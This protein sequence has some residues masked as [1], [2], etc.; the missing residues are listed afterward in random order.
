MLGPVLNRVI[1]SLQGI[2]IYIFVSWIGSGFHI[3]VSRAPLPKFLL[4]KCP[5][6]P[7][8]LT[9]PLLVS[10]LPHCCHCWLVLLVLNDNDKNSDEAVTVTPLKWEEDMELYSRFLDRKVP[11][12]E[13]SHSLNTRNI[14][15]AKGESPSGS[16]TVLPATSAPWIWFG[17]RVIRFVRCYPS[18]EGRESFFGSLT[19]N[20][21]HKWTWGNKR[22]LF[23][24]GDT[25][26]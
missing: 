22:E 10:F 25:A 26:K 9:L 7:G 17:P 8:N 1:R 2:K 3:W 20:S 24:L 14:D 21:E 5:L 13:T 6:V 18:L 23:T 11:R 16:I 4:S 15:I 19:I 12:H